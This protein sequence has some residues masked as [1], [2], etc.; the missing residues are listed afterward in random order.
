MWRQ[1]TIQQ[2]G[3]VLS[4]LRERA[5]RGIHFRID[6]LASAESASIRGPFCPYCESLA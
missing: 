5:D 2:T 6:P 4:P 1:R 3:F